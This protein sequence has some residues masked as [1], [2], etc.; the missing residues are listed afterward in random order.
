MNEAGPHREWSRATLRRA[1]IFG[2][3]RA[4]HGVVDVLAALSDSVAA[5]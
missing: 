3:S 5:V 4:G 2:V 1:E